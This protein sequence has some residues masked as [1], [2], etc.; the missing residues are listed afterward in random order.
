M[1]SQQQRIVDDIVFC[2]VHVVS[3]ESRQLVLPRT[4]CYYC[5]FCGQVTLIIVIW[6][7]T[8]K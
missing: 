2:V 8:T 4:F 5:Y 6:A 1:F 3:E 7:D